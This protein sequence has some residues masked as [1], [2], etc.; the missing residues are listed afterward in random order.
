MKV[1]YGFSKLTKKVVR[2]K[3]LAIFFENSNSGDPIK[4]QAWIERRIV[5]IHERSQT[6][7]ESLDGIGCNRE[8]VKYGYF[9]DEKPFY[10]DID[11]VLWTN[12]EADK[13]NV[14]EHERNIIY[15]KLRKAYFNCYDI[16]EKQDVQLK[17]DLF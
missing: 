7:E 16:E 9:I 1:W 17:L 8:F 13:N 12:S 15:N 6:K 3:E 4:K 5:I 2:K 10:G 11:R 14:S